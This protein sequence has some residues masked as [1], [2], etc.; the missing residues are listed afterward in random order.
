[1]LSKLIVSS[2]AALLE[3]SLWLILI[4]SFMGGWSNGGLGGA[5]AALL[6]AFI[7][8]TVFFG[9]FLTLVDIR[10]SVK[11]MEIRQ[12]SST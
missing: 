10:Q 6:V 4:G 2:Y 7:L 5:L 3:L 12:G 11:A 9:A 1:M 8:C